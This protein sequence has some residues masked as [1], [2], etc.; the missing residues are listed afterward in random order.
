METKYL[1]ELVTNLQLHG[2]Q[3]L[4]PER[5]PQT[6]SFSFS[7]SAPLALLLAHPRPDVTCPS[8]TPSLLLPTRSS[9]HQRFLD[10]S[11]A[12]LRSRCPPL[13]RACAPARSHN[14]VNKSSV[15]QHSLECR[16]GG[17]ARASERVTGAVHRSIAC[18]LCRFARTNEGEIHICKTVAA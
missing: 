13:P 4:Y 10:S 18:L 5:A 15:Y 9:F 6:R 7:F 16:A 14:N 8:I 11:A 2:S 17:R 12:R 3:C 1:H